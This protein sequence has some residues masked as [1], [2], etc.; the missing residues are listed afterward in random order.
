MALYNNKYRIES[1]RLAGYDYGSNGAYHIT[2]CIKDRLHLFGDIVE[3]DENPSYFQNENPTLS[4]DENPLI[5]YSKSLSNDIEINK[6]GVPSTTDLGGVQ[7]KTDF[8]PSLRAT[9]IGNVAINNW[10]DIPNHYPF[11]LLD[12]FILMPNHLHGILLICKE[13]EGEW[14]QNKFGGQS[15]NIPSIIRGF[16]ASVKQYA[17]RKNISFDW[18][19]RYYDRIIRNQQELINTRQYIS[20]NPA[21]WKKDEYRS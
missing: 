1:A 6:V 14:K 19:E 21:N 2:I 8:H 20:N 7:P 16:K 4:C 3:T 15:Q 9:E 5:K 18:Q 17:K 12:S 13:E 11:V 10:L